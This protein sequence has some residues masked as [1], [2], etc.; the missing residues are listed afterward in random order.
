MNHDRAR[1]HVALACAQVCFGLFPV[2]GLRAMDATTG[3]QSLA[4]ATWRIAFGAVVLA[5]AAAWRYRRKALV[6]RSDYGLL[7]LL[8]LLGIVLNQGLFLVGLRHSTAINAGLLVGLIPVFT[9]LVAALMRQERF[10]WVR[11]AGVVLAFAG[12]APLVLGAE[13]ELFGPH[14]FG[15]ALM[16][17]NTFC[18]SIYLVL[19]KRLLERYSPLVVLAWVYVFSV[20]FLPLFVWNVSLLPGDSGRVGVW[21]DLAYILI[22]PTVVAYLLNFYALARVRASTTAFYVYAQPLITGVASVLILRETFRPGLIPAAVTL[23]IGVFCVTRRPPDT[24]AA[25]DHRA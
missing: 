1:G 21:I 24:T 9:F 8:A 5:S 23:F 16:A 11:A 17:L 25:R 7:V 12:T 15:N 4:V 18:F 2:F 13:V 14:R 6:A 20:P 10:D 3:F 22:F 19:S